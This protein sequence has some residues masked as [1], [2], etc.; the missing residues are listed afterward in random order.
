MAQLK[1]LIVTGATRLIGN[2]YAGTI[3][4]TTLNAPTAAGGTTYGP[5]TNGYVLKSNG[6]SVYW[7]SDNNSVTGVKG[8]AE[9]SYRTGQI[10]LTAA[11]VGAPTTTG[12]GASGTWA[13]SITGNAAT[14]T[15][16]AT[17]RAING[18]AFDGSA[19]ITTANWGTARTITI[20]GTGKS[21]NGSANI[22]WSHNEIGAT[23]SNTWANGTTA[24]PTLSTTVNGVTGAAVAIPSA[25]ETQSGIITTGAQNFS[26]RKGFNLVNYY[27]KDDSG[28]ATPYPGNIRLYNFA[29]NQV[30]QYWYDCG[31]ATNVTGGHFWWREYSP[32]SEADTGTT[33]FYENYKLPNVDTGR[34]ENATYEIL[35]EKNY[36]T[37]LDDRY[38][39]LTTDQNIT[40]TKTWGVSGQGGLLNGAATNGGLNSIR[41]GDDIWLGDCNASGI[42]GMK[43]TSTN[44]GFYFYNSSDTQIGQLYSNGTNLIS[45]KSLQIAAGDGSGIYYTGT[46]A[47]YRMIRFIDNTG[48]NSGNGISIGGGGATI[49]GGGESSNQAVGQVNGGSEVMYI[50]NDGAIE[51][52]PNLQNGWTTSYRNWIDTSGY[53][54]GIKVYG[55]VWNDYAEYRETKKEIEPG[56]CVREL[57]DDTL[58]L[59]TE[60]LQKGCEIVSDTFGFAIGESETAKTPTAASGRVLAYLYEDREI[61]RQHIGDPV[62]SGPNGTVSIMTEEE[63]MRY[64]SRIIGTISA[65]PDYE[66]WHAGADGKLEIKVN[67]RIWI[68]IR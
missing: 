45:N 66:I 63:E 34:T 9:S 4:I 17:A 44:C 62:C 6:S 48:D 41:V 19:D 40:G 10:N 27:A 23:V 58:I 8:N 46:K 30:G 68:R 39:T 36:S 14:A 37:I 60:R 18:T 47:N 1:D 28:A 11:N 3:Q 26:G 49:I 12:T 38:V 22:S 33:E 20:G 64:P 21:V 5:G 15:K 16:L 52:F 50:C 59:T 54:H 2:A 7:G 31:D 67:G 57:G 35:T 56:R 61:A 25:S 53:Y 29:G 13:I 43:S 65:V 51:F 55:A 42:M 24:G 32:K